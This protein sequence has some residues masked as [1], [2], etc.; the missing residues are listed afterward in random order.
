MSRAISFLTGR[1]C[2]CTARPRRASAPCRAINAAS[3]LPANCK[4]LHGDHH[5]LL[6]LGQQ[7]FVAGAGYLL[8]HGF[9]RHGLA[10][11][12]GQLRFQHADLGLQGSQSFLA[13]PRQ[14]A[15]F[16]GQGF[17]FAQPPRQFLLQVADLLAGIETIARGLSPAPPR[18]PARAGRRSTC[19]QPPEGVTGSVWTG[20]SMGGEVLHESGHQA[21]ISGGRWE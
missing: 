16:L 18:R 4:L 1:N 13:L 10:L 7:A 14:R 5:G 17:T 8:V 11:R 19:R 20:V 12:L 9:Q 21:V 2:G 15:S 3:T 6:D